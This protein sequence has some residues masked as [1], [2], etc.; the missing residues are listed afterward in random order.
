MWWANSSTDNA[1][2]LILYT[3]FFDADFVINYLS[4]LG[5]TSIAVFIRRILLL[6]L[7]LDLK[8]DNLIENL[9]AKE[10]CKKIWKH[11]F[12][13]EY[14]PLI[15]GCLFL[16]HFKMVLMKLLP[17]Q[18]SNLSKLQLLYR[19]YNWITLSLHVLPLSFYH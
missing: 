7:W 15:F 4:F 17:K 10:Y 9:Y 8:C 2:D 18:C 13:S 14:W 3:S 19:R 16:F 12:S 1:T 6:L 11:L 5:S